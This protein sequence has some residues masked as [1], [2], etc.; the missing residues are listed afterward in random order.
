MPRSSTG[1]NEPRREVRDRGAG[2]VDA[3]V[4]EHAG[5]EQRVLE[6]RVGL[7][8]VACVF[9]GDLD[10]REGRPECCGRAH[11]RQ[12][13]RDVGGGFGAHRTGGDVERRRHH[14]S[15]QQRRDTRTQSAPTHRHQCEHCRDHRQRHADI[16]R[17]PRHRHEEGDP[18]EHQKRP[19]GDG[20]RLRCGC[21]NCI[22]RHA[23]FDRAARSGAAFTI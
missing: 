12:A 1:A 6:L 11:E 2:A 5:H 3:N 8:V 19:R 17:E 15:R 9:S 20:Q 10:G 22:H 7:R 18:G 14:D 23:P 16:Q 13:R 21:G 4:A